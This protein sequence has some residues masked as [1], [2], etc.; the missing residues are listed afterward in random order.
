MIVD[1]LA[2]LAVPIDELAPLP[3]NPRRGDVEAVARSLDLDRKSVV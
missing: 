2:P 3:G 1:G